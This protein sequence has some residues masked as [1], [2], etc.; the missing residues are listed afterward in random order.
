MPFFT[1]QACHRKSACLCS[2]VR[3][4]W[5]LFR[6]GSGL[7]QLSATGGRVRHSKVNPSCPTS[8]SDQTKEGIT[9]EL[10]AKVFGDVS[11]DVSEE[12]KV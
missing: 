2:V 3:R 6:P 10:E 11:R 12:H 4:L 5:H 7:A 8:P 1:V 9:R